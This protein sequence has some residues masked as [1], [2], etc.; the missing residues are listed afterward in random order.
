MN[1]L[2]IFENFEE[3]EIVNLTDLKNI[4][5]TELEVV[6]DNMFVDKVISYHCKNCK[7]EHKVILSY[8]FIESGKHMSDFNNIYT[9]DK[10]LKV[11]IVSKNRSDLKKL[12]YVDLDYPVVIDN[13]MTNAEK[14][15]L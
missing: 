10:L 8:C 1:H 12:H 14:F 3:I 7:E 2:K 15:G 5:Y 9:G 13:L 6:I 4:T 11:Y